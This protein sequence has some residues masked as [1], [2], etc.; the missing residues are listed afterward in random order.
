[1]LC[2]GSLK[3]V[4]NIPV[5]WLLLGSA[6]ME[7]ALSLNTVHPSKGLE[8]DKILGGAS[9]WPADPNLPKGYSVQ[10]DINSDIKPNGRRRN[11]VGCI[12]YLRL[13]SGEALPVLKTCFPGSS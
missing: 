1:M 13:P 5:F 11:E 9:T 6:G 3:D 10:Y 7:S 2:T 8:V 4:D 12:H